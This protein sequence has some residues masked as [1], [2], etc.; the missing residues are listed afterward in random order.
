MKRISNTRAILGG[1][2]LLASLAGCGG[3]A[4]DEWVTQ[5]DDPDPQRRRAA[6]GQLAAMQGTSEP[7]IEALAI[8]ST[9]SD[10]DV[11]EIAVAAL[12]RKGVE[13]GAVYPALE[14]ALAD[15][16]V[17]VRLKAA[18]AIQQIDPTNLEYREVLLESL[19]SGHGT[20]FLDIGRMGADAEWA[21]PTLVSSLSD[22]RPAIRALAAK[23]L[24]E[25]HAGDAVVIAALQQALRDQT[26]AVRDAARRSLASISSHDTAKTGK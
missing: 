6:A 3:P 15:A 20:V 13:S 21:V 11:R 1:C 24:G 14:Q 5:L 26:P 10:A 4:V 25:I 23:T 8:A 12:G 9:N 18:L 17:A 22:Q 2:L 19:R 7:V 16:E